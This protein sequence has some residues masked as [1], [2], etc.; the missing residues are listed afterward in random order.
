MSPWLTIPGESRTLV[1]LVD[2]A[3][4]TCCLWFLFGE[5]PCIALVMSSWLTIPGESRAIVCLVVPAALLLARRMSTGPMEFRAA[6][7]TAAA[8]TSSTGPAPPEAAFPLF[9][10]DPTVAGPAL[11]SASLFAQPI[12][13]GDLATSSA[14]PGLP[15]V[16]ANPEV[17]PPRQDASSTAAEIAEIGRPRLYIPRQCDPG[18]SPLRLASSED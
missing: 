16:D 18:A 1:R 6:S 13:I 9:L 10:P 7:N 14:P 5:S 15:F 8:S 17:A 2:R 3:S 11:P 4:R 12:P